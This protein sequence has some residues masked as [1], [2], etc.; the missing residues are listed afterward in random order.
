VLGCSS[1]GAFT[2]QQEGPGA[3]SGFAL[4]GDFAIRTGFGHGLAGDPKGAIARAT[5]D[6]PPR[7]A[8]YPERTA[9]MLVDPFSGKGEEA[10]LL[11]ASSFMGAAPIRLVGGA[12][13]DDLSMT[14]ATVGTGTDVGSD[15]LAFAMIYSKVP[16]GVG[17]KHGH[18]E[19]CGPFEV[20]RAAGNVVHQLDGRPAWDVWRDHT[21]EDAAARGVDVDTLPPDRLGEFLLTYEAALA[22][23]DQLK[24]RAPLRRHDDGSLAFACGI[25]LGAKIRITKSDAAGQIESARQA[26]VIARD[27]LDGREAAGA[28]VFDCICRRLILGNA[29]PDAIGAIFDALGQV[30]VA[31][32]ETYGE[33]ALDA[34]DM[35]GFHNSTSVVLAVPR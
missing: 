28:L 15:A 35:S 31:G 7:L 34:G 22:V 8:G 14:R 2:D 4:A 16:F 3:V 27:R 30:P 23:G 12:A 18:R 6:M 1:A 9:I 29:F 33:I 21:R 13:G 11:A 20:T 10:T 17:V 5:F 24:V 26:A 32:F 25:A 19:L